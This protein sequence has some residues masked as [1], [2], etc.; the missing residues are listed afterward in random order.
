MKFYTELVKNKINNDNI[1]IVAA[2]KYFTPEEMSTLYASG[3]THF[4]E[5]RTEAFIEKFNALQDLDITWHFIGTL[6]TKKV[7]KVVNDIDYLHSLNTFKLAEEINKRRTSPLKCFIQVNISSE[8]SKH[9][10]NIDEVIP[11]LKQLEPLPNI[12]VIGLM[13][14]AELTSMEE[15]ISKEFQKLNDLQVKIKE[16]LHQDLLELSIGM[17]NDY[18]IALK[19]NATFL[20]LGSVLFKKE[21]E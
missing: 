14:M 12:E 11:F 6:Q 18:L 16:E 8:E 4:G 3:I 9:G 1:T 20:R 2:T 7:K 13:G 10:F 21:V 17:S 19:H 15:I 5:N